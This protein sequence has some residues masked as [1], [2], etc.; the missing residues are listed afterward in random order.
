MHLDKF[1]QKILEELEDNVR[2]PVQELATKVGMK[3]T[4]VAYR[5]NKLISSGVLRFACLADADNLNFQFL[6]GIGINVSPG[7][8]ED[9]IRSLAELNS[10][11]VINLV[12]GRYGIFA[13]ALLKN[14]RDLNYF[15]NNEIGKIEGI[16][17]F[18]TM[19]AFNWVRESWR[20]F[21]PKLGI[22][23]EELE[24]SPTQQD[25]AIISA[26]QEDPRQSITDL[27]RNS[28]YSK[29]VA[30][31]SLE[32][33]LTEGVIRIVSIVDPV[34]LG[35]EIEVSILVKAAPDRVFA[36]AEE[37]SMQNIVRHV[38]LTVGNWQVFASALF[39][40][41]AHLHN[42]LSETLA[43]LPGVTYYEVIQILQTRK[44]S[45][46]FVDLV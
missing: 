21:K 42:Y 40:D 39:R 18:E 15:I 13:W 20:Y 11:K 6:L 5:L 46:N 26:L 7:K 1:D 22:T 34:S 29:P 9:V 19:L 44:F 17:A 4:T 16:T 14:R 24:Y 32:R 25:L 8:S 35:F 43:A 33:L 45:T 30:R 2:I 23:I 37:L 12:A 10:I 31:E 3:R 36:I 27:A 28:G 38:S 41:N